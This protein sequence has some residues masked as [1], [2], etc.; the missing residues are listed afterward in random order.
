[1][2]E[3]VLLYAAISRYSKLDQENLRKQVKEWEVQN[4]Q[5]RFKFIP[6]SPVPTGEDIISIK[7]TWNISMIEIILLCPWERGPTDASDGV[8][9]AES[10]RQVQIHSNLLNSYWRRHHCN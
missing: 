6:A 2:V 4:P 5:E 10:T 8:R 9:S 7:N 3:I 1:M